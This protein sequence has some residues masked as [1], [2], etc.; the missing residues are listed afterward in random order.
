[1]KL[2]AESSAD[3]T[4][5][6]L[7]GELDFHSSPMLREEI[8]KLINEGVKRVV[9]DL[10]QL[11]FMDSGGLSVL[12]VSVKRLTAQGGGLFLRSVP[13]RIQSLLQVSGLTELLPS[14]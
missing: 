1:M 6:H 10:G 5:I 7:A 13:P 8:L 12:I 14:I 3:E 2:T 9:M 4:V 11:D